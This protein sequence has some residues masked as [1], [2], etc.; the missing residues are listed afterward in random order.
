MAPTTA[1]AAAPA[2]LASEK[3]SKSVPLSST[4]TPS[5]GA[6]ETVNLESSSEDEREMHDTGNEQQAVVNVNDDV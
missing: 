2:C 5:T 3:T 6:V 4:T 1:S